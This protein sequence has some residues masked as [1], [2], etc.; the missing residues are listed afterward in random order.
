MAEFSVHKLMKGQD[1]ARI[2]EICM[3]RFAEA[4]GAASP[5]G[6]VKHQP[7]D[8]LSIQPLIISFHTLY[9]Y[10]RLSHHTFL[11]PHTVNTLSYLSNHATLSY[12]HHL[13]LSTGQ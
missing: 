11:S 4:V 1:I 9:R 13:P 10:N 6:K 3:D 7:I 8:I 12:H 5:T 2:I